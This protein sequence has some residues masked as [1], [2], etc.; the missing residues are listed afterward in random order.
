MRLGIYGGTFDP[1]HYGH[2]ILAEQCREQC[3]LDAVWFVPARR[4]PHKES[5][6]ITPPAARIDMLELALAGYPEFDVSLIEINREGPSYTVDT[7]EQLIKEDSSRELFLLMG[8]DSLIDFP[9][10]R[11]PER[12]LELATLV[13]VNRGP[14]E[15]DDLHGAASTL[16]PA[17]ADRV[18]FVQMPGID[19]SAT[20]LRRR[21]REGRSIRFLTPRPV[22]HYITEH[23][24][25]AGSTETARNPQ[26]H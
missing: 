14:F 10:W 8:R 23:Q 26:L 20:D 25:Y 19:I 4:P 3:E 12:I 5:A 13:V 2:L 7:L 21:T 15:T 24:L 9:T 1:V 18:R 11:K 17:A 6:G 16:G 22:T